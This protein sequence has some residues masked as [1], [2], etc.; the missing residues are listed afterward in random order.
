MQLRD[1]GKGQGESVISAAGR[2]GDEGGG[3]VRDEGEG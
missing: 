1:M 2:C 3:G